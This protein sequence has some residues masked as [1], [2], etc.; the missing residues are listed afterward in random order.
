MHVNT[1]TPSTAPHRPIVSD[2]VK[3]LDG[4]SSFTVTFLPGQHLPTHHNAS[5][6]LINVLQGSGAITLGDGLPTRLARGI[7]VQVAPNMPHSV[8][9][10]EDGMLIEVHLVAD[11]CSAC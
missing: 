11:C 3:D 6:V 9:A 5:R 8:D 4:G 7:V 1:E 10:S 2:I